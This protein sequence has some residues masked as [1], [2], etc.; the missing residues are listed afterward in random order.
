MQRQ[1]LRGLQ[2]TMWPRRGYS[3]SSS[4]FQ[5]QLLIVCN[6]DP[7]S[8]RSPA[9]HPSISAPD[10]GDISIVQIVGGKHW[11]EEFGSVEMTAA[12]GLVHKSRWEMDRSPVPLSLPPPT[13]R[14][15]SIP[16]P[17][18]RRDCGKADPM[19]LMDLI[20]LLAWIS[21]QGPRAGTLVDRFQQGSFHRVKRAGETKPVSGDAG[22]QATSFEGNILWPPKGM[23]EGRKE[24]KING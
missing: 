2:C 7:S 5:L 9:R 23:K 12:P 13:E 19:M 22:R 11:R 17:S 21:A 18:G 20:G 15:T 8:A 16:L 1:Q 6:F 4:W 24:E 14:L 10:L 3:R